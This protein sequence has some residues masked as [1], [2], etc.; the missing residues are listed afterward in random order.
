[1]LYYAQRG[2]GMSDIAEERRVSETEVDVLTQCYASAL[3]DCKHTEKA[4][5]AWK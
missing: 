4:R 5:R 3:A 1:M 2:S